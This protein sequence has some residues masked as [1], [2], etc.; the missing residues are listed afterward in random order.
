[1]SVGT[2]RRKTADRRISARRG[3]NAR[4]L[5]CIIGTLVPKDPHPNGDA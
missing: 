4:L 5:T 3:K 1:M 2:R